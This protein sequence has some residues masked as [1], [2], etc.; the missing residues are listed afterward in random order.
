M[1]RVTGLGGIFFKAK[2][3]NKQLQQ[4][5]EKH[6]EIKPSPDAGNTHFWQWRSMKDPDKTGE[7]VWSVFSS[8]TQY[9][10]PSASAFMINYRVENLTELLKVLKEEGVEIIGGMEEYE[11]GK[12][13][14]ILD[15]DGNKIELWEP[16][17][18]AIFKGGMD[19]E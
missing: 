18:K 7:T 14:W 10:N 13:A 5:Y 12:F 17:E 6:L 19:M 16:P 1:K 11:Y 9:L 2:S 3:D 8:D 15:P 4:W